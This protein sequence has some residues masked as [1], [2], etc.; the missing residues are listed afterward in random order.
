M[1]GDALGKGILTPD[2]TVSRGPH[3]PG[4]ASP[5]HPPGPGP[6]AHPVTLQRHPWQGVLLQGKGWLPSMCTGVSMAATWSLPVG[7]LT[8]SPWDPETSSQADTPEERLPTCPR[9]PNVRRDLME[10]TQ[11]LSIEQWAYEKY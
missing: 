4:D 9:R 7:L 5:A 2:G 10:L 3:P 6:H 1:P 11:G 8:C